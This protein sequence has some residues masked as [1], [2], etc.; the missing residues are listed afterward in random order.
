MKIYIRYFRNFVFGNYATLA[1]DIDPESLVADLKKLIFSRIRVEVKFQQL[2]V[3]NHG[4]LETM[5]DECSLSFYNIVDG[6][7]IFLENQQQKPNESEVRTLLNSAA[8]QR[9]CA[10]DEQ[11]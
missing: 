5:I 10:E 3:K 4:K 6:V 11:C 2:Q 7:F 1:F 9:D 8:N